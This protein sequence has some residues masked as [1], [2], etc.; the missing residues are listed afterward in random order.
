MKNEYYNN[1]N[2]G[3]LKLNFNSSDK[4]EEF[5]SQAGQDVFVISV[6]NGKKNGKFLDI[7]ASDPKII[8]N[9]LLLEKSFGWTGVQIEID[10]FLANKCK[11]ERSSKVICNDATKVDY[12]K[13]FSELGDIDYM[14]LDIDGNPS[15]EVLKKIP[16]EKYKIKVVT[17]EHDSYRVGDEIKNESRKIFDNFGYIRI[18]SNV[19]NENNVY[20]DWY[21]HQDYFDLDRL[22]IIKSESQNWNDILFN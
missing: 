18:C 5:F 17:F 10:E 7:G 19:A 4:V 8:N 12:E 20:E 16:F 11:S 13:I 1:K 9:T 6:M 15:L 21:V 3:E 14:S 22:N 2:Y